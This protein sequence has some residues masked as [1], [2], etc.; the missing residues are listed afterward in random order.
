MILSK[1]QD[2]TDILCQTWFIVYSYHLT[3]GH[4]HIL[5]IITF[6]DFKQLVYIAANTSI[7]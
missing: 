7:N 5:D 3:Y 1:V 6:V 2:E 4:N